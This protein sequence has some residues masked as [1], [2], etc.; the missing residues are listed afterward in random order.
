MPFLATP[1]E[2]NV[3]T[4]KIC[5]ALLLSCFAI[6]CGNEKSPAPDRAPAP[7]KK[8][9]AE[10]PDVALP[11][12][13]PRPVKASGQLGPGRGTLIIDIR[14]PEGAELTQGAPFRVSATG[15]DLTFPE[16]IDTKL[17]VNALP[18]RLPLDIADGALGPAQVD[19][20]YYYCTKGDDGSCRPERAR[21]NVEMDISGSSA[22]GEAH[23]VHH[24]GV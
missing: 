24:P 10:L 4:S 2:D 20:T 1:I 23:L 3:R 13:I 6:G 12:P 21:L 5:C 8:P 18:V 7:P 16:K 15:R 9:L 17:D 14:A 11:A 22:G 19:L